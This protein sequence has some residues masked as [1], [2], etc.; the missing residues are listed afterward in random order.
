MAQ[1]AG[2]APS[3]AQMKARATAI[4][5]LLDQGAHEM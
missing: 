2:R 3:S 1:G 5:Q 4:D